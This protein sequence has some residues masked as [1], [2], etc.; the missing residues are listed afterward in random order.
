MATLYRGGT[1]PH[2]FRVSIVPPRVTYIDM[3]STGLSIE[4]QESI[5]A[6]Y[7]ER[8][9]T[10]GDAA[11]ASPDSGQVNGSRTSNVSATLR[12]ACVTV[13]SRGVTHHQGRRQP[14]DQWHGGTGPSSCPASTKTGRSP[15]FSHPQFTGRLCRLTSGGVGAIE[16]GFIFLDR[17]LNSFFINVQKKGCDVALITQHKPTGFHGGSAC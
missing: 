2:T 17:P 11:T 15:L 10:P 5:P 13:T 12:L 8:H 3:P 16:N 1:K 9:E 7:L 14:I 6:G 4:A